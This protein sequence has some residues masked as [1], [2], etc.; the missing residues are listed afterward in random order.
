MN[1]SFIVIPFF[2]ATVL[3]PF[4]LETKA[5]SI[6]RSGS[7][8]EDPK[9]GRYW[10]RDTRYGDGKYGGGDYIDKYGNTI[11]CT[12]SGSCYDR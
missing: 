4:N 3:S 12:R 6:Y 9:T 2:L 11:Y 7:G 5:N 10:E 8:Y 1:K